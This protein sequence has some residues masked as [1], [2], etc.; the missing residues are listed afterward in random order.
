[1]A[2]HGL[3]DSVKGLCQ[4]MGTCSLP[5]TGYFIRH[6]RSPDALPFK[7]KRSQKHIEGVLSDCIGVKNFK[8]GL[9]PLYFTAAE[10]VFI[11]LCQSTSEGRATFSA[12]GG[13]INQ[14]AWMF[15]MV[16]LLLECNQMFLLVL[17]LVLVML[18]GLSLVHSI[19]E[20]TVERKWH[21][22]RMRLISHANPPLISSILWHICSALSVARCA[23]GALVLQI[24]TLV[25]NL[26]S[27]AVLRASSSILSYSS[28]S[29]Y[30]FVMLGLM[31]CPQ[32]HTAHK[33]VGIVLNIILAELLSQKHFCQ[34][35]LIQLVASLIRG[36]NFLTSNFIKGVVV[37][38]DLNCIPC[39]LSL[40][41]TSTSLFN[42]KV[43][44][45]FSRDATLL[46]IRCRYMEHFSLHQV[47]WQPI[48]TPGS[49]S[50]FMSSFHLHP[51]SWMHTFG[52]LS[53]SVQPFDFKALAL[54]F[55]LDTL[56][57][58]AGLSFYFVDLL[59]PMQLYWL[60]ITWIGEIE[61]GLEDLVEVGTMEG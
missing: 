43:D 34:H 59:S 2:N 35:V 15:L 40:G 41:F 60:V 3:D 32:K 39:L 51:L 1:M 5:F 42:F 29:R 21:Y 45:C 18:D 27:W 8:R 31:T 26:A 57:M 4:E 24:F 22:G 28:M 48:L 50:P 52:V 55:L 19:V 37:S 11:I 14:S 53:L 61:D 49:A 20:I 13:P 12:D 10:N 9:G 17:V 16:G 38:N 46:M 58:W 33:Q 6:R 30:S 23:M 44:N 47:T 25:S 7:M 36:S 54:V 56:H